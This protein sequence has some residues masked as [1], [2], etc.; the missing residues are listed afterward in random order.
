MSVIDLSRLPAPLVIEELS[1]EVLFELNK[2][3]LLALY[4]EGAERDAI[5]RTLQLE[6]EPLVKLLQES[7]YR[8]LLLRQRVNQAALAGMVAHSQFGDLDQLG[9][10]NNV[11]R[12]VITPADDAA[13]PPVAASMES[14]SDY[15]LRIPAAFEGMSVAGPTGAYEFHAASADGRVADAS[16]SSPSPANVTITVLSR[17]GDGTASDE[18]LAIVDKALNS[19]EIRPV[20]DRLLIQSANIVNYQIDATLYLLP[21]PEAVPV[22][23]NARARLVEYISQQRR[24]GRDIRRSAIYAALHAEGVQRVELAAPLKD[25]VL[26]RSQ[27]AYCTKYQVVVGGTDE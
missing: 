17:E 3:R 4:P 12:L 13:I 9:A 11:E 27:A 5:T 20:A 25:V 24:L 15:R 6:S 1:F 16:A 18:L 19:E 23:E 21:G 8:E 7:T 22:M 10:N 14:D 26:D 2:N